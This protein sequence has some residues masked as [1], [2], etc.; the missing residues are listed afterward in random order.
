M[1]AGQLTGAIFIDFRKAFDTIDHKVLLDKLQLFGIYD[2]EHRWMTDYLTDRTQSV[3][4]GGVLSCPQQVVSGVPQ[5]SI[6]G[7]LLFS[8][9]VKDLPNCLRAAN[10][11]MYADDTVIYYAASDA[12]QLE[13]V[14]NVELKFLHDWSTK[15]ELFIHPK[16]TEYVIFGT[17]M[18]R[19]Q[20]NSDNLSGVYLGEQALNCRPFYKYLGV[21]LDQSLSFKEHVTRLVDKVS[22]QLGLLSRVR[23][24][25]TVHA[26]ERIFTAMILPKLDY[27]DFVWNNLAPSRYHALER[28]QT[29][30]AR[31]IL[32]DSSLSHEHLLRQLSWM[33]LKARCNMHIVT[34]VFKCVHNIAPDLFKE[35]FVRTFHNYST[36][37]NGLDI[38]VP[39]VSTESAKKGCYFFGAQVFNNLPSSMKETESL[40]IFKTLVKD[41][42]IGNS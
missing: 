4:V 34:F 29:R 12:N 18:K 6:L 35:Y 13:R 21:Y 27:C 11:L 42:Y 16:K 15:N 20:I 9:Y 7:P 36:R 33:S 22:R 24:N 39:K 1:D 30:A 14:L 8:L 38:F 3:F 41:F 31:I 40:L 37:R 17:T 28:L 10:V 2:S 19:N 5:G 25:L 32:K 23:N 26:A